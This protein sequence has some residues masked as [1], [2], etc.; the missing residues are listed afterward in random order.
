MCGNRD[1]GIVGL[2]N[3]A[4]DYDDSLDLI[5]KYE[6]GVHFPHFQ[7][8]IGHGGTVQV[9]M[10]KRPRPHRMQYFSL[11]PISLDLVQDRN[12][13]Q[14]EMM[15]IAYPAVVRHVQMHAVA[16]TVCAPELQELH[17]NVNQVCL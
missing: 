5:A 15:N 11:K 7:R 17:V 14:E 13:A 8:S 6:K 2:F 4:D 10:F 12:V 3:P 1:I 16:S 9:I